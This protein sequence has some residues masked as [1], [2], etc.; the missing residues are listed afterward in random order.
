MITVALVGAAHIHT[1]G[2]IKT[3]IQRKGSIQVTKVWDHDGQRA[4]FRADE[5]GA[6]AVGEVDDIWRDPEVK[7]VVIC[8]ETD[9]HERLVLAAAQAGKHMFVEKP[10]G[11]GARDAAAMAQAVQRR[12]LIFQTGY[13]MRSWPPALFLKEQVEKG[14]LGRITRARASV[15]HNGALQGL[16]DKEWRWMADVKQAGIGAFGD[17]GTHGL[18]ILIW[19][20][21]EV[22]SVTATLDNG[23]ARYRDCDETGE[24]IL[25]FKNGVIAT[26]A[27]AW[28][29]VANPVQFLISGTEAHA[30]IINDDVQFICKSRGFDGAQPLKSDQLPR[31]R[32]MAF[33]MFL[34]A[35]EGKSMPLI[36]ASEAAYRCVVMEAIY[37]AAR[38]RGWISV[39]S[40][41]L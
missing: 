1:P 33:D 5:L 11:M 8:S 39:E 20:F 6:S 34:D 35:L 23:T 3:I 14:T 24:A 30:A 28:D 22:E 29:D 4:Q 36:G 26:L 31:G 12:G 2:F 37:R 17:L 40:I 16:F 18:D 9:R 38:N 7:A 15:S 13:F 27:A 21:G 32:P 25:R 10:L 19:L 41:Q